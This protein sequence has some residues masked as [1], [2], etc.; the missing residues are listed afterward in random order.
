MET[1][2][3]Q[4]TEWTP[5]LLWSIWFLCVCLLTQAVYILILFCTFVITFFF[6]LLPD[7]CGSQVNLSHTDSA[8]YW[9]RDLHSLAIVTR[10][11]NCISLVNEKLIPDRWSQRQ[12]TA[13]RAFFHH[14]RNHPTSIFKYTEHGF[15]AVC[16]RQV[17]NIYV[18]T[19]E[20]VAFNCQIKDHSVFYGMGA[21]HVYS[22]FQEAK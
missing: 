22:Q 1:P 13:I 19:E 17:L 7:M 18:N 6:F 14:N 9:C 10:Q 12:H 8:F 3:E 4:Q 5:W 16:G 21:T 20:S 2:A 11:H 15:I